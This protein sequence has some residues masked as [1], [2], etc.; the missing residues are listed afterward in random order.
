MSR[1]RRF[2]LNST[3]WRTSASFW[4]ASV[5]PITVAASSPDSD[6]MCSA[7]AKTPTT[8]MND[9]AFSRSSA[10]QRAR[11]EKRQEQPGAGTRHAP[12]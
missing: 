7:S 11:T 4:L 1:T 5:I 9:R 8:S 6:W 2:S 10:T 3:M 12:E